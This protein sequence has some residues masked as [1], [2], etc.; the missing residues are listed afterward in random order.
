MTFEAPIQS[1][2][3]V[4]IDASGVSIMTP[5][6]V[7]EFFGRTAA[8]LGLERFRQRFRVVGVDD[9]SKL[10]INNVVR[11]RL[12]LQ[13]ADPETISLHDGPPKRNT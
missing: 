4:T 6:F 7:D 1:D 5:S 9:D 13:H 10:L 11:N 12:L 8:E 3:K 2:L